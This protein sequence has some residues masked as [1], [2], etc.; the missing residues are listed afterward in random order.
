MF[1]VTVKYF[2]TTVEGNVDVPDAGSAID[3]GL[4]LIA[5]MFGEKVDRT[6]IR[7]CKYIQ[8]HVKPVVQKRR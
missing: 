5:K 4:K 6:G 8:I 1:K 7:S 3:A 2:N